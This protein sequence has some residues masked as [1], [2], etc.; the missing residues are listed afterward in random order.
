MEK[1]LNQFEK[2]KIWT[3]VERPQDHFIIGTKWIFRNKMND[4]GEIIRNKTRLVVKGYAQ[5]EGIDFDE[6]FAPMTRF[7]SI[8]MFLTFEYFKNFKLF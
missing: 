5:E 8:R 1:E 6:T 2:K 3:L 4:K 7:E